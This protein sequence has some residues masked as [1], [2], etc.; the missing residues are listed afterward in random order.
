M[1]YR[2]VSA[3]YLRQVADLQ[4]NREQLAAYNSTGHCVVLA[5]PGSGKTKTL[6]LKLARI[7]SE[8]VAAPRG[9]ACI[10]YSHECARELGRR[11][12]GLSLHGAPNLFV[13]T[14]HGFC[15]R[16][17][18]MPYAR[19]AR[20]P[21]P[22]PIT[23][24]APRECRAIHNDV[25]NRMFGVGH[26]HKEL[27]VGRHRRVH[28]DRASPGWRAEE[29]LA[30]LAEE[31]EAELRRRGLVDF[32]DL[33]ILGH[34]LVTH[35][36]WVL[37]LVGA[38]FPVLAV[39][40]YQDLGVPLHRIV[41]RL[42]FHG[43][44]RLFAVGDADQSIYGFAGADGN[45]LMEL[46][47]REDVESIRLKIN[48]RSAGGI[49]RASEMALGENR[50]YRPQDPRRKATIEFVECPNGLREQ[51]EVAVSRVIPAALAARAGRRLGD[52]A[53]LYRDY[54]AGNV[55]AEEASGADLEFTR[56]DSAAPYRKCNLTSWIE[57]CASWSGGGWRLGIPQLRDLLER[58]HGFRRG[59]SSERAA[60]MSD[61]VVAE[62]LWGHRDDDGL[63]AAFVRSIR[64][65]LIDKLV[66]VETSLADQREQVERMALALE[67]GGA[68]A[69]LDLVSFGKRDG[70]PEHLNLLTLHS[71]K[72]CEYD[73]V[74]MVGLDLGSL[75]WRNERAE[76]LRESRRLFYVG[77]TRARDEVYMLYSGW[78]DTPRGR[79][80][81]GRSPFLDELQARME[82]A[83]MFG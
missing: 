70:S 15:L 55:V 26:P 64:V 19:L 80:L 27:L 18:L 22:Y 32:D 28:L 69:E 51:A 16:H 54:R 49:V 3:A 72:G 78:V 50:G 61:Q 75:P 56:V 58:W 14:V 20:L 37:P 13:G 40:E 66:A 2:S 25:G 73:V 52:I 31:Y 45:L 21:V 10:T 24:A 68:L 29:E 46:A 9:V 11:L 34:S 5:G 77:L 44:I 82:Q 47:G 30:A 1:P 8:E 63:A 38:K 41:K 17:L 6:V 33:V 53:I 43:G 83:E 71:A 4:G 36:D 65:E 74:V 39:D 76:R 81:W 60:H 23:V 79:M 7:L 59:R 67:P 57:D 12:D 35:Y 62:F 42:A 48:Y